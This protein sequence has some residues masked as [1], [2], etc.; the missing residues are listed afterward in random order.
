VPTKREQ[1]MYS[2]RARYLGERMRQLREERGLTL[3]YIASYLGVE[4][5]TLAR[6][7]RAEWP[8]RADHVTALLDVYG[9]FGERQREE[10]ITLARN[11]W[12][13]CIWEVAGVKDTATAGINEQPI[14]DEWWIQ[15]KAEELCVYTPALLPPLLQARDYAEALIRFRHPQMPMMKVE[16]Q[17]RDLADRQQVLYQRPPIRLTVIVEEA[18]LSRR[19]AGNAVTAAQWEQLTRMVELPH[20]TVLVLPTNNGLHV[21]LDGGFTLCRMH[22]PYPP[23]VVLEQLTGRAVIEADAANQYSS[24]FDKL[25]EISLNPA[26]SMELIE[27]MIDNLGPARFASAGNTAVPV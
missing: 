15:S 23:V 1:F 24:V 22:A 21:G 25:K 11:A 17:V 18:A 20:V 13:V 5:S 16:V 27:E 14:I 12:R 3:K 4:F 26:Q 10:L 2:I 7:E 9:V 8:F 19:I 6:Y